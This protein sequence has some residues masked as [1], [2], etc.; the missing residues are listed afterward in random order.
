MKVRLAKPVFFGEEL[1]EI[2][3]VLESG[4]WTQGP[5]VA[6]F[7]R[8]FAEYTGARYAVAVSSCTAALHLALLMSEQQ[9][10]AVPDF[11]FPSIANSALAMGYDL[12]LL[13]VDPDTYNM[14]EI[15]YE[16]C[17][18][19]THTFGNP[20]DMDKIKAPFIIEDAACAI[21]SHFKDKHMGTFGDVG[22][23]SFHPRKLLSTGKGGMLI[24]NS[25]D[26]AEKAKMLRDHG[27]E[28]KYKFM[29]QGYNFRMS[30]ITAA[31]GIVQLRHMPEILS[32]RRIQANYYTELISQ[33]EI[34]VMTQKTVE[35]ADCNYQSYVVR[36]LEHSSQEVIGNM[37]ERG[38]ETQIGTYAL[39]LQPTFSFHPPLQN[40]GKLYDTTL[41]L[42]LYHELSVEEQVY[43]IKSL[44][45]ICHQ[46]HARVV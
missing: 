12:D 23:F 5:K 43:V 4:W 17:V 22:C 15:D 2:K 35:G 32:K 46:I 28:S 33:H 14:S 8:E 27:R 40:S 37:Y 13:D 19:P 41:T 11:T 36:L 39:H 44:K 25:E 45:E 16:G 9:S 42:P 20:C 18:V 26:L 6:E 10:V 34:P 21:G 30:D 29:L 31:I 38:I 1:K 24:T 3:A 7:E